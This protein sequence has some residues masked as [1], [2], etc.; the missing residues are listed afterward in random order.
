MVIPLKKKVRF[1]FELTHLTKVTC[2]HK[3]INHGF[4]HICLNA[5]IT[6]SISMRSFDMNSSQN[7]TDTWYKK[8]QRSYLKLHLGRSISSILKRCQAKIVCLVLGLDVQ[9]YRTKQMEVPVTHNFPV[10][11]QQIGT[12]S[13]KR[14][15]NT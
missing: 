9:S 4:S 12:Q 5:S 15:K 11:S 8:S 14:P 1:Q 13:L 10:M 3:T 2:T 7:M 6:A